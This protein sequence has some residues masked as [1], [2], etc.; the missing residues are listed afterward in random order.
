MLE[1]TDIM[2]LAEEYGG[3]SMS[4]FQSRYFVVHSHV[5]DYR[6][7]RQALMEIETRIAALKQIE[8]NMKRNDIKIKI[9]LAEIE[10]EPD[11]LK[12][13]L[14][15]VDIDQWQYD[16]SVYKNKLRIC[17]EEIDQFCKIIKEFVPNK[18]KLETYKEHDEE[19]EKEYWITRMGKQAAMDMMALGRIGQGNLD[20]IA[21]MPLQDQENTIKLAVAY[22][23]TLN[24][25]IEY[26]EDDMKLGFNTRNISSIDKLIA[27]QKKIDSEAIE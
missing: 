1:N 22:S 9:Q 14:L 12:K 21:M 27:Q 10:K 19:K 25:A 17:N 11:S 7:V 16:N 3:W 13:E 6:R 18:E 15:E 8:R 23:L 5:T 4:D 24:K 20:S 2:K 26:I